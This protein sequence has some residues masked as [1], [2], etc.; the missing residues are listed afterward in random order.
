[1]K[2]FVVK[3]VYLY[4]NNN[5]LKFEMLYEYIYFIDDIWAITIFIKVCQKEISI[6]NV[7]YELL[8]YSNKF[9]KNINQH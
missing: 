3:I 2:A 8:P 7:I 1:M 9:T 5:I 4:K 6:L